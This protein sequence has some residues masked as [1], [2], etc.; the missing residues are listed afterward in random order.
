MLYN[1]RDHPLLPLKPMALN[2]RSEPAAPNVSPRSGSDEPMSTESLVEQALKTFPRKVVE[3]W[4]E[5]R[6]LGTLPQPDGRGV[7]QSDCGDRIE[8]HLKLRGDRILSARFESRGCS[9]TQ[10]VAS[11]ATELATGQ[12]VIEALEIDAAAIDAALDGLPPAVKHCA[13]VAARALRAAL[14]DGLCTRAEPW[15]RLYR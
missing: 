12:L 8:I 15:K 1:P 3:R 6:N 2:D 10:A 5:P 4:L 9:N 13:E 11:M 14:Q 7:A